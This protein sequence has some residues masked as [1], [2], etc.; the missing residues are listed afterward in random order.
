MIYIFVNSLRADQ[1]IL[2]GE[3]I[4]SKQQLAIVYSGIERNKNYFANLAFGGFH[5]ENHIGKGWLWQV[6]KKV[7]NSDYSLEITEIR[8]GLR[9]LFQKKGYV[10][11]PQWID[12]EA[13]ISG[14]ISSLVSLKSDM[15]RI[16]N[17]GLHFEVKNELS[18]YRSFYENMHIPYIKRIYG[19]TAL[20]PSHQSFEKKFQNCEL[21]LIK[22][23]GKH[24]AGCVI[25]YNKNRAG[26]YILGV[27]DGNRDFVQ[28]GALVASYYFPICHLKEKGYQKVSL[29]GARPF[30]KD[31]VLVYKK[32]WHPSIEGP[33]EYGFL[34]NVM[35]M[36]AGVKGFLINNPFIYLDGNKFNGA[37]FMD[38]NE[39]LCEKTLE[40]DCKK[41]SLKGLSRLVIYRLTEGGREIQDTVPPQ[42]SD[43]ITICSVEDLFKLS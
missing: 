35:S 19:N 38:T 32:K 5:V 29:G 20:I 26:L 42:F 34:L 7:A 30:V 27:K 39:L 17:R 8:K 12:L 37:M 2:I 33:A 15:R 16:R 11:I 41:Y 23:E 40:A 3:E 4:S 10:Y 1:W 18:H 43:K 28:E 24:I 25:R 36:T 14:D 31:G 13:D 6:P 22:K 21:I 9:R